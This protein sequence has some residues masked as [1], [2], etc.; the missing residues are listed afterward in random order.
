MTPPRKDSLLAVTL[1]VTRGITVLLILAAV[2][3]VIAGGLVAFDMMQ[4]SPE[5]RSEYPGIDLARFQANLWLLLPTA[6]IGIGLGIVFFRLLTRIVRSVRE[7]NPFLPANARRLRN[8]GWLALGFQLVAL[9]VVFL[10]A[11]LDEI[12]GQPGGL[13][14]DLGGFVLALTLFV[15]ARVFAEGAAM[16]ADLEGTV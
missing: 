9:P 15:L 8:M 13:D 16:R 1:F 11:R 7:G 2:A 14:L 4:G 5:L 12:A 6:L 10:E 3:V